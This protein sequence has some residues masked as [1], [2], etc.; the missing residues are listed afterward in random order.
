M[1]KRYLYQTQAPISG[2]LTIPGDKSISHRAVILGALACGETTITN[3]L[4]S[5][6]CMRT[7]NIFRQL[8]VQIEQEQMT[9]YIS[10]KGA[11]SFSE[12]KQPLYLGNSGT[13]AR[14]IVG[15]LAGLPMFITLYG[16]DFLTKRPM[17]RV[18]D[19]LQKMGATIDGRC[20]GRNLPLM[21]R[22]QQLQGITYRL[23]VKSAQVK[24]AL[25]LAGLFAQGQTTVIEKEQTR[26]HTE[27]MLKAFGA[28]I[29]IYGKKITIKA[30]KPLTATH[31]NVPGDISSAAFFLTAAAIV[32]GSQLILRNIGLNKTRTGFL[33]ILEQMNARFQ[34]YNK[35]TVGGER[36][37]DI[38][39]T[40]H[41][42]RATNVNH[43]VIPRLIDEIPL[44]ALLATQA[45]G[46]TIIQ[47]AEELRVKE[48]DRISAVV[49]ILSKLGAN[50]EETV[51]G[52]IIRGPTP[53]KGAFV[54]AYHDHRM[55]MMIAI[56]S[57][58]AEGMVILDDDSSINIS[59]PQFFEHLDQIVNPI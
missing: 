21:I 12:P 13:T 47:N 3:F 42:L 54:S 59:Y 9:L 52:M 2:E 8:G 53:L 11:S 23:P 10:S 31:I 57:L 1:N 19:P 43:K 22:G 24:S 29:D 50:I 51:D 15:V 26:D 30:M 35:Q 32:P 39:I 25:L 37:G 7:V 6:D 33:D 38:S 4:N 27:N 49:H 16:D 40:Y 41:P 36:F 56:A 34:I 14:L 20:N 18:T 5:D 45:Q 48:T 17:D 46:T 58:V 55:A 44:I 28:P